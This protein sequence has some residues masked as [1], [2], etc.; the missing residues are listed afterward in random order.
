MLRCN[1]EEGFKKEQDS[2]KK[3]LMDCIKECNESDKEF[4]VLNSINVLE[5][6]VGIELSRLMVDF[7]FMMSGKE[8]WTEKIG[9]FKS[10]LKGLRIEDVVISKI[11]NL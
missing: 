3:S 1:C 5:V 10:A 7:M 11:I 2:G 4:G 8:Q 9:S 6:E